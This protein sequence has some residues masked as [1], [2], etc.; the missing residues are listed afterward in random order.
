VILLASSQRDLLIF[1]VQ[2]FVRWSVV[3]QPLARLWR[4]LPTVA[5]E[6]VDFVCF[7]RKE[8]RTGF[9]LGCRR[10]HI[11]SQYAISRVY[12]SSPTGE[13]QNA[14]IRQRDF[15]YLN[16]ILLCVT[17]FLSPLGHCDETREETH[18]EWSWQLGCQ[19]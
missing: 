3:G 6:P 14:A 4:W 1:I 15:F 16:D 9:V 10:M 7:S 18:L 11:W 12:D 13:W 19:D 2:E 8:D 5:V 17:L